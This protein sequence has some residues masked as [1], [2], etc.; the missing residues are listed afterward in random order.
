MNVV[1]YFELMG[2]PI[3]FKLDKNQ[4][5]TTFRQL[6]SHFHPDVIR[7]PD[8][9]KS[10][11]SPNSL[12]VNLTNEQASAVINTAYQT[13][14]NPDSRATHLLELAE[15][16]TGLNESIRDL[17]FLDKAMDLRISLEE[18]EMTELPHLKAELQDWINQVEQ[19]FNT[20]YQSQNWQSAQFAT[21]QL[22]FLIKL[23][24][25]FA[26]KTDELANDSQNN[27]DD[28]YV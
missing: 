18:A 24:N 1:N 10:D 22:K 28:L 3:D 19:D 12:L 11:I 5:D 17:D 16:A 8:I 23:Q 27:D 25:D 20:A 13:L 6:Q 21:Q 14:K 2:L 9:A 7:H 15:Q 4:L 26:K